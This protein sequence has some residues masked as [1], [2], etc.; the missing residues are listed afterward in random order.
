MR[1]SILFFFFSNTFVLACLWGILPLETA[2]KKFDISPWH[3]QYICTG[4]SHYEL[5][6]MASFPYFYLKPVQKALI[7]L[8]VLL[9]E[10]AVALFWDLYFKILLIWIDSFLSPHKDVIWW[11]HPLSHWQWNM[12]RPNTRARFKKQKI[13]FI[14]LLTGQLKWN[15]EIK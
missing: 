12:K 13:C 6:C 4:I 5:V 3:Q 8:F 10:W 14:K 9:E 15:N 2:N 1:V 11:K 7:S